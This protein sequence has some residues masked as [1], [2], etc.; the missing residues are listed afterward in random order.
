M[1]LGLRT[2]EETK[3][4]QYKGLKNSRQKKSKQTKYIYI[5]VLGGG[6]WGSCS[7]AEGKLF[8][9]WIREKSKHLFC[10]QH[11]QHK[12]LARSTDNVKSVFTNLA[13]FK[14]LV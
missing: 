13:I 3:L 6:E 11:C 1:K 10:Y 7:K 8:W 9:L 2:E 14:I 4:Q 5:Y 12:Q